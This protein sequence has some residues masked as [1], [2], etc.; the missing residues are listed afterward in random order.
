MNEKNKNLDNGFYV[1]VY[2]G[3]WHDT[4]SG[5]SG[6]IV[7]LVCRMRGLTRQEAEMWIKKELE[8]DDES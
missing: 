3:K 2:T 7:D 1:N 4:M 5:E 6:D 8:V